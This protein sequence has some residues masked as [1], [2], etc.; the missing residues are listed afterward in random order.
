VVR[1]GITVGKFARGLGVD[2]AN[3]VTGADRIPN[4]NM[5]LDTGRFRFWRSGKL[6]KH[7]YLAVINGREFAG[8]ISCQRMAMIGLWRDT[9]STLRFADS[10]EFLPGTAIGKCL[11]RE[12][13]T[14][15]V[16][17]R[18]TE[19]DEGACQCNGT[20]A[21]IGRCIR[22]ALQ[23]FQD[24][25]RFKRRPKSSSDRSCSV[26]LNDLQADS[27]DFRYGRKAT[28]QRLCGF[29]RAHFCRGANG[30][31]DDQMR[32]TGRDFLGKNGSNEL[33]LGVDIERPLCALHP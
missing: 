29:H 7:C 6:G 13:G 31:V 25:T 5:E 24:V 26:A 30:H 10:L 23:D 32:R 3:G 27:K 19:F 21:K 2:I 9:H 22:G 4:P 11:R 28:G 1:G 15:P 16:C 33:T 12:R 14:S 20:L 18:P 17:C 8:S